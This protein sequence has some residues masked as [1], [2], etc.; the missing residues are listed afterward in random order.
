MVLGKHK[1]SENRIIFPGIPSDLSPTRPPKQ[2]ATPWETMKISRKQSRHQ[3]RV[4]D[5]SE[6]LLTVWWFCIA[7]FIHFDLNLLF[8]TQA[9]ENVCVWV[10]NN[11]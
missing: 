1:A 3:V 11:V 6:Q 9:S 2:L 5:L 7:W 10:F 8:D 4:I